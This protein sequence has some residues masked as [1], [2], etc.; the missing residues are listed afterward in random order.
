MSVFGQQS[1]NCST[2]VPRAA[3]NQDL[4]KTLSPPAS[5]GTA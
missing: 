1:C 5:F 2:D 3:S 4:H